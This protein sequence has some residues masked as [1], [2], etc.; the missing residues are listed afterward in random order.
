MSLPFDYVDLLLI[1]GAA[2]SILL[3]LFHLR[4]KE[5]SRVSPLEAVLANS[6]GVMRREQLDLLL[7]LLVL[8]ERFPAF[9]RILALVIERR[10]IEQVAENPAF[11]EPARYLARATFSES[12]QQSLGGALCTIVRGFLDDPDVEYICRPELPHLIDQFI[13]E[14]HSQEAGTGSGNPKSE[15]RNPR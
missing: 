2:L 4:R 10:G 14:I 5:I 11:L 1:A 6:Q 13:D 7:P 3:I 15:A 12:A 8:E 9:G